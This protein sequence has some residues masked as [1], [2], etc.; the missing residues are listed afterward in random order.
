MTYK[1]WMTKGLC[2]YPSLRKVETL[3]KVRM[4]FLRN[5]TWVLEKHT[6]KAEE[7]IMKVYKASG[8]LES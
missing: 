3:A 8:V 4:G 5:S 7:L 1:V 2:K 6:G